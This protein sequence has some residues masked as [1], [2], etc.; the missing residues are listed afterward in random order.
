MALVRPR[1]LLILLFA[2]IFVSALT[3]V[4][5]RPALAAS[6]CYNGTCRGVD[7]NT[8][9]KQGSGFSVK[10]TTGAYN[11]VTFNDPQVGP[12]EYQYELRY[13]PACQAVWTRVTTLPAA[14]PG[15]CYGTWGVTH[16]YTPQKVWA[17]ATN[18]R[19]SC[20][21]YAQVWTAMSPYDGVWVRACSNHTGST[22]A[23]S[24]G[25]WC[26]RYY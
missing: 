8:A 12:A 25:D 23:P 11:L 1:R 5:M 18:V 19:A 21:S 10:C 20:N 24:G 2:A 7:P 4:G 14:Y 17:Y 13:S 22:R 3:F 15:S 9:Y 6:E 26:S 16:T